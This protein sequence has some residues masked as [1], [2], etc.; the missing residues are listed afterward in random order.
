M[1]ESNR[2]HLRYLEL[3]KHVSSW[4]KDTTKV[5]A[6]ISDSKTNRVISVGYNGFP[7]GV[8]DNA[9]RYDDRET[10]LKLVC[11]A[12]MNAIL[13]SDQSVRGCDIY[14][15]PTMMFPPA[16]PDC[17]KAIVQSGIKRLFCYA[18]D[19]FSDRW[20]ELSRFSHILLNE[21]GVDV[22]VIK[23]E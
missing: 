10:K 11:H 5:G 13:N 9:E 15:Y 21:G 14:V 22:I 6:V 3:A 20:Q 2:W 4:S 19:D 16:C 23:E 17:S 7:R 1:S 8:S 12:E 18:N